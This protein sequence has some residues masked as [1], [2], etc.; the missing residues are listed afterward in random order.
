MARITLRQLLDHAAENDYGMPAFN[1]NNME[2]IIAIMDAAQAVDAPAILQASRGARTYANDIMLEAMV[3]AAEK[4]Y[5]DIPICL[6]QD[7]G[8][9]DET[10]F[11]GRSYPITTDDRGGLKP[12]H[13][14][15]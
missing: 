11:L 14:S 13:A 9:N 10:N 4:I 2:Q 6:H 5:P 1:I 3:A 12:W 8:N 15:P 7:H